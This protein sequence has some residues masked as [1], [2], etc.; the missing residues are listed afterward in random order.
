M[1]TLHVLKRTMFVEANKHI[2]E[3][4][5]ATTIYESAIALGGLLSQRNICKEVHGLGV[6]GMAINV[7]TVAYKK[8]D[9]VKSILAEEVGL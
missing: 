1:A 2:E 6:L 3:L 8:N 5:K 4:A 9:A 7:R